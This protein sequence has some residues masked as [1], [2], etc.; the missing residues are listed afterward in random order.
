MEFLKNISHQYFW[1]RQSCVGLFGYAE[2]QWCLITKNLPFCRL[3]LQL[4]TD[5]VHGLSFRSFLFGTSL[6]RHL[7]SWH[8][9]SRIFLPGHMGGGLVL[10]LTV[11]SVEGSLSNSFQAV[12]RLGRGREN[13]KTMY[14]LNVLCLKS[15]KFPF[16]KKKSF[17]IHSC[18][19]I[20]AIPIPS[21]QDFPSISLSP[22]CLLQHSASLSC[23]VDRMEP[24]SPWTHET[25][26]ISSMVR[27]YFSLLLW[28][29]L[30][31]DAL[32]EPAQMNQL[33]S[34]CIKYN[35]NADS[36]RRDE[37]SCCCLTNKAPIG[38]YVLCS[39]KY[40]FD[41]LSCYDVAQKNNIT[42]VSINSYK[43]ALEAS[44]PL[45][46]TNNGKK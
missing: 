21:S 27:T 8:R 30:S 18:L 44:V 13:F 2:I 41:R 20:G 10:G 46:E 5:S 32:S 24:S 4:R 17:W 7:I 38:G 33:V 37:C 12:C 1:A 23:L 3:S 39:L 9:W 22:T 14:H 45:W 16:S 6:Q 19:L 15:I 26:P 25:P 43:L 34:K 42:K 40:F 11:I 29:I 31:A 28:P 36:W 35:R